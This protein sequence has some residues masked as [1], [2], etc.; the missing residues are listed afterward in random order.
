[1]KKYGL[2][3]IASVFVMTLLV[4]PSFIAHDYLNS[5]RYNV[6]SNVDVNGDDTLYGVN[7]KDSW[8][9]R[10]K[11]NAYFNGEAIKNGLRGHVAAGSMFMQIRLVRSD[12][13]I[14]KNRWAINWNSY[15]NDYGIFDITEDEN[16]V[17][18]TA[19]A[20]VRK[21]SD[22][23]YMEVVYITLAKNTGVFTIEAANGDF[24]FVI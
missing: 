7:L 11:L 2:L 20:R 8:V 12:G 10:G 9:T 15:G 18:F 21:N 17:S 14:E 16:T 19:N 24:K 23:T 5:Q 4:L 13:S 1:M 22:I 3:A 6:R